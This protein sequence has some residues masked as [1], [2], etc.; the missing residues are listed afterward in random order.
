M[1]CGYMS[2][3]NICFRAKIRKK[4]TP[5]FIKVGCKGVNIIRTCLH[6]LL[7]MSEIILTGYKTQMKK[8][9]FRICDL[10]SMTISV[11]KQR[12]RSVALLCKLISAF[13]FSCLDRIISSFYFRNFN[14]K[15]SFCAMSG[16]FA[17]V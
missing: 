10:I 3:H 1:F 12:C 8:K 14:T 7:K 6:D 9:R 16:L 13:V 15:A 11:Y 17:C 5:Y 4:Y 2:T